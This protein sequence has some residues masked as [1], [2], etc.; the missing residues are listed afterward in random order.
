MKKYFYSLCVA[1]VA[2][3]GFTACSNDDDDYQWATVSGQQ[4]YFANNLASKIEIPMSGS[5]FTVPIKRVKTDEA[6]T[7]NLAH[8]DTTGFYNVPASV[9]FAAGQNEAII[10]VG[11]DNTKMVYDKFVPDTI[12]ITSTDLTSAYGSTVYA[13]SAGALSPYKTLGT[14]TYYDDFF[15]NSEKVTIMQNTEDTNVFRIYGAYNSV[16]DGNQ[17]EYLEI[18]I[19]KP[20]D[21]VRGV[22]VTQNDLVYWGDYNTGYHHPSYDDDI[23]ILHPSRFT[24]TGPEEYWL[25]SYVIEYQENGLPGEIQLAPRYYMFSVGGW[26]YSQNDGMVSIVFPGFYKKDFSIEAEPLGILTDANGQASFGFTASLGADATDV[27]AVIVSADADKDEAAAA[28]L[29]DEVESTPVVNG[30]NF[31]PIPEGLVGKLSLLVVVV[32]D[33]ELKEGYT[34]DFEYYGG[35]ANPWESVGVGDYVY[36]LFFG[37]ADDPATDPGL[38]L[39]YNAEEDVYRIT[40]WGYDVDF[41]FKMDKNTN[42]VT[43]PNQF[44][45]YTHSTYG[46]V[47]IGEADALNP[48]WA[49]GQ[50]YYDPETLAFHFRV[51]Y[52]VSQGVF[53]KGEEIFTLTPAQARALGLDKKQMPSANTSLIPVKKAAKAKVLPAITDFK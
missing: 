7:V 33:G 53:G 11:Y 51:A 4:V 40:H 5:E 17:D 23:Y 41:T 50:S 20:G 35:S 37:S 1:L 15:E 24:N 12:S 49:L 52:F 16:D 9:S 8:T 6:I 39:Q 14:G 48:A 25:H 19:L 34:A 18:R 10:T 26:N 30:Y 36:T 21:E 29:S 46:D 44:T 42:L 13:F 22:T 2:V 43:V 27:R 47:Y 28:L 32:D 3:V 45:G 31:V 38:E